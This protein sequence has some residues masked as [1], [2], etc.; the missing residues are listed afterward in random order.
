MIKY[1]KKIL[2]LMICFSL[3]IP[4]PTFAFFED[5]DNEAF[6]KIIGTNTYSFNPDNPNGRKLQNRYSQYTVWKEVM[7]GDSKH[8]KFRT[9]LPVHFDDGNMA[10]SGNYTVLKNMEEN[11]RN[12]YGQGGLHLVNSSDWNVKYGWD[13]PFGINEN[14]YDE[15][16][17]NISLPN[18]KKGELRFIGYDVYG[19]PVHNPYFPDDR[20]SNTDAWNKVWLPFRY[21]GSLSEHVPSR[22]NLMKTEE[23]R[24]IL[25]EFF[26][27]HEVGQKI[28]N[29]PKY[30]GKKGLDGKSYS[31]AFKIDPSSGEKVLTDEAF[32]YWNN[33]FRIEQRENDLNIMITGN[34]KRDDGHVL[35]QTFALPKQVRSSTFIKDYKLTAAGSE[36]PLAKS[37]IYVGDVGREYGGA[38][39]STII[40]KSFFSPMGKSA[41]PVKDEVP[42]FTLGGQYSAVGEIVHAKVNPAT[43]EDTKVGEP[44]K[45]QPQKIHFQYQYYDEISKK[46][47]TVGPDNTFNDAFWESK[48]VEID[49]LSNAYLIKVIVPIKSM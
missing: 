38:P 17:G 22:I 30:V 34:W 5:G 46:W 29:S 40:Q 6:K 35:Y 15:K 45:T 28:I 9:F 8:G 2:L 14:N 1:F 37:I 33:R 23:A 7:Y 43:R 48:E 10:A 44:T 20:A 19:E 12:K 25:T 49:Y 21:P 16:G 36:D 26:R 3:T 39:R 27:D 31:Q 42:T 32:A 11:Q 18:G 24:E 47:Y 13:L 41:E 4:Y